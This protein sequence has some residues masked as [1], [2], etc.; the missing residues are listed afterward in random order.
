MSYFKNTTGIPRKYSTIYVPLVP[1]D[2]NRQ[3]SHATPKPVTFD[4]PFFYAPPAPANFIEPYSN[5]TSPRY[6][7]D[8]FYATIYEHEGYPQ[9]IGTQEV[10]LDVEPAFRV[11]DLEDGVIY[12]KATHHPARDFSTSSPHPGV[13]GSPSSS[14]SSRHEGAYHRSSDSTSQRC[15][16]T[17]AST[18][19]RVATRADAQKHHIPSGVSLKN[20]DPSEEP[21][22]VFDIVFDAYSLGK[23][24][25]DGTVKLHGPQTPV[26]N[27]A[28]ELWLLLINLSGNSRK[29]QSKL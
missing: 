2:F 14:E 24:V 11:R 16:S 8:G 7:S 18:Q 20:W 21:L 13:Y 4:Q 1:F 23:C 3:F 6:N 17:S 10:R 12:N 5:R 22:V 29:A 15:S 9:S 28:E 19:T 26:T 25:Y 27:M